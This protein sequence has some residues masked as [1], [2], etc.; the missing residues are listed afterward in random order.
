VCNDTGNA[1]KDGTPCGTNMACRSGSCV[2]CQS[3]ASCAPA[4]ACDVGT[5]DC[6]T[7]TAMCTD[8]GKT[9]AAGTPCGN[10]GEQCS[11]G[12]CYSALADSSKWTT[13]DVSSVDPRAAGFLGA[14]FDGRYVY[15][16][17]YVNASVS[18]AD[19]VIAR[20]D[21]TLAAFQ[22][23][24]S[25]NTT[26]LGVLDSR[27]GGYYGGHFDG[28]YLY[29]APYVTPA[30]G[31]NPLVT[32]LD[33]K[34]AFAADAGAWSTV[35]VS[36]FDPNSEGF[37]G[38]AF[39]GRYVY[40]VPYSGTSAVRYDTQGPLDAMGSWQHYALGAY[41]NG[42][43]FD[44]RYVYFI[45]SYSTYGTVTAFDTQASFTAAASWS[46]FDVS[47]VA[48]NATGFGGAAFDGRYLYLVPGYP[49]ATAPYLVAARHD[50]QGGFTDPKSW[51]AF[52]LDGVNGQSAYYVAYW[53]AAFDG[54]Y[55]YFAPTEG[56]EPSGTSYFYASQ[57]LRF[58]STGK[59]AD[60]T[61][62]ATYNVSES[63]TGAA[64]F[65]GAVIDGRY[66]YF[67]PYYNGST[68]DGIV[69]RFDAKTP[70]SLPSLCASAAALHCTGGSL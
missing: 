59:F 23:P 53:G 60:P 65:V 56:K 62:W 28:R 69:A 13:F 14:E 26:D 46:T 10:N 55:V 31:E 38:A 39:D 35:D 42:A 4:N 15:F 1:A 44:G 32:R 20:Y 33:T 12:E 40:F 24:T 70:A 16:V 5:L 43:I 54:R 67:A 9:A 25:W 19:G 51:E 52:P 36:A 3:G 18:Y 8:T 17:P 68:Y 61:A 48:P 34:G 30:D 6:S 57:V 49:H 63:N 50:T 21:T 37:A 41:Y 29:L 58:D 7:G 45:S 27:A 11:Q 66:V 22:S 47:G 64:G 2:P